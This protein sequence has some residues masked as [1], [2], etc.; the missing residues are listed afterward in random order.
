MMHQLHRQTSRA[1]LL[2]P[3]ERTAPDDIHCERILAGHAGTVVQ[4]HHSRARRGGL[5]KGLR[6][7]EAGLGCIQGRV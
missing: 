2:R 4:L 5:G 7:V 1:T 3:T 6:P